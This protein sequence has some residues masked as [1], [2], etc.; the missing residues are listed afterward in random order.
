[1]LG[2]M[3]SRRSVDSAVAAPDANAASPEGLADCAHVVDRHDHVNS[4][5]LRMPA[6]M[7]VTGR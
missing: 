1:M 6:S 5:G 7:I 4:I 2:Q 3:L